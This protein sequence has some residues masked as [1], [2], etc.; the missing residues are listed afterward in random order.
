VSAPKFEKIQFSRTF[1]RGRRSPFSLREKCMNKTQHTAP[2]IVA[3]T[4]CE[5]V[6]LPPIDPPALPPAFPPHTRREKAQKAGKEKRGGRK[7][8]HM[9]VV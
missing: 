6:G 8:R 1:L 7:A 4:R 9:L 2:G 5:L 3:I